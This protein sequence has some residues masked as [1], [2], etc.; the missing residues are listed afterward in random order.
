MTGLIR[1]IKLNGRLLN[2]VSLSDKITTSDLD[3]FYSNGLELAGLLPSWWTTPP[4]DQA[5]PINTLQSSPVLHNDALDFGTLTSREDSAKIRLT[6]ALKTIDIAM[7]SALEAC[8]SLIF[9]KIQ[10]QQYP[11]FSWMSDQLKRAIYTGVTDPML[12]DSNYLK[13]S[14]IN[15]VCTDSDT[16]FIAQQS[17]Y[18]QCRERLTKTVNL[19][20]YPWRRTFIKALY[21]RWQWPP[22]TVEMIDKRVSS[23]YRQSLRE[24]QDVR[25]QITSALQAAFLFAQQHVFNIEKDRQKLEKNSKFYLMTILML[26]TTYL[27]PLNQKVPKN[28]F[29]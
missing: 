22:N 4:T 9:Q 13:L 18:I 26:S 6:H 29:I 12:L 11:N 8:L 19:A 23:H 15:T 28:S 16:L 7:D 20:L 25:L 3:R 10:L 14:Y 1:L 5:E 17:F 2:Q 27:R 21:Q 24:Y